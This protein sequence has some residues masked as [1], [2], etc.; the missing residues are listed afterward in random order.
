[1]VSFELMF[2][3]MQFKFIFYSICY[4]V[5]YRAELLDHVMYRMGLLAV[6]R[7]K[8]RKGWLL[9]TVQLIRKGIINKT[10]IFNTQLS[11]EVWLTSV[12]PQCC[13]RPRCEL[14]VAFRSGSHRHQA[15]SLIKL[16]LVCFS[17]S[18]WMVA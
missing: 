11:L 13:D 4:R 16:I 9:Y 8:F 5:F 7:S 14:P 18:H 12:M 1:M 2:I 6:L 15:S 17:S 3:V 10:Y